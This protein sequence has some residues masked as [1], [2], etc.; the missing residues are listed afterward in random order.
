MLEI[1]NALLF[2]NL[3][4]KAQIVWRRFGKFE[5]LRTDYRVGTPLGVY[6][7]R[8]LYAESDWSVYEI[9]YIVELKPYL[10]AQYMALIW[11][12]TPPPQRG[13]PWG[14]LDYFK[15]RPP[16]TTLSYKPIHYYKSEEHF[17]GVLRKLHPKFTEFIKIV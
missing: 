14:D 9:R 7:S 16:T 8:D 15:M 2:L 4:H 1:D 6:P 3:S 13:I 11:D 17:M 12:Y 5:K 10:G